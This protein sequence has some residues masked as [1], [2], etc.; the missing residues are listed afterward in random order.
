MRPLNHLS[1]SVLTCRLRSDI[2]RTERSGAR[3]AVSTRL[4]EITDIELGALRP[5]D[6]HEPLMTA[7]SVANPL[8]FVR[9][10][11]MSEPLRAFPGFVPGMDGVLV[12]VQHAIR[13]G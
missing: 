12:E 2:L 7:R 1:E 4:P 8:R 5:S 6:L 10:I 9:A 11:E 13:D 3:S